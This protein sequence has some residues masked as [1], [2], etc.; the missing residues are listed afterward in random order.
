MDGQLLT[1][2]AC[3]RAVRTALELAGAD[4]F[5][6]AEKTIRRA[7]HCLRLLRSQLQPHAR[8]YRLA[9]S[10]VERGHRALQAARG[11]KGGVELNRRFGAAERAAEAAL[12]P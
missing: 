3:A 8:R 7:D 10:A 12:T 11:R 1:L 4:K 2:Q 5:D 6:E 9:Q